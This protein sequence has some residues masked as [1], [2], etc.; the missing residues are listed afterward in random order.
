MRATFQYDMRG[1]GRFRLLDGDREVIATDCRTGSINRDGML[2]NALVPGRWYICAEPVRT[3][4]PAMIWDKEPFGWK[5]R[6][7]RH[8]EHNDVY[9][10]TGFLVH[11]DG[12]KGGTLGCIGTQSAAWDLHDA[13]RDAVRNSRPQMVPVD[14]W[15]E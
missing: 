3:D 2:V 10:R 5:C 13:L 1:R 11:P 7:F 12:G 15:R 4:E 8:D 6:L 9:E 14:V